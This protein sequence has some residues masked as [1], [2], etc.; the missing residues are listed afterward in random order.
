MKARFL[1]VAGCVV[2]LDQLT[3]YLVVQYAYY[4]PLKVLSF[5]NLILTQNRGISFGILNVSTPWVFWLITFLAIV[6]VL[7]I[8]KVLWHQPV[9][10]QGLSLSLIIGGA[11]GNIVDR[12]FRGAVVDFLDFH[13]YNYHWPAFNIADGAIVVGVFF[14]MVDIYLNEK[15]SAS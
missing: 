7:I 3:K 4:L 15:K 6:I 2:F 11:I 5:F 9:A 10:C 12:L 1:Q 8:L 13:L 14:L